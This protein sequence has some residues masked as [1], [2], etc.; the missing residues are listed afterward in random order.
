MEL[1]ESPVLCITFVASTDGNRGGVDD[2]SQD[3]LAIRGP[4]L[5]NINVKLVQGLNLLLRLLQ[6]STKPLLCLSPCVFLALNGPLQAFELIFVVVD[7]A[8][9][10]LNL[11]HNRLD[12]VLVGFVAEEDDLATRLAITVDGVEVV[13][14]YA[15]RENDMAGRKDED[16]VA[17]AAFANIEA[18]GAFEVRCIFC[19]NL[20]TE[21]RSKSVAYVGSW[22]H[23]GDVVE[24]LRTGRP[25]DDRLSE[26]DLDV[27]NLKLCKNPLAAD[28]RDPGIITGESP[29]HHAHPK[30]K[31]TGFLSD[32]G[33]ADRVNARPLYGNRIKVL[34][35]LAT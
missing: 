22:V 28:G 7:Q 4:E 6:Q 35:D 12:C 10:T 33:E 3:T 32:L 1:D 13:A 24:E 11:A 16:P 21:C 31:G 9:L 27:S 19:S 14:T 34:V 26:C 8:S 2:V 25:D 30:E 5:R 15:R 29:G 17:F 18:S 20:Q 23:T